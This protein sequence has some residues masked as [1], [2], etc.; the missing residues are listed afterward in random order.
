M[1]NHDIIPVVA[2]F[3]AGSKHTLCGC[4]RCACRPWAAEHCR[5]PLTVT[6]ERKTLVWLCS[7]AASKTFPYCDGSHNPRNHM[8]IRQAIR[9]IAQDVWHNIRK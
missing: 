1:K 4:R 5:R 9:A 3:D 6:T 2:T 8:T 7:C